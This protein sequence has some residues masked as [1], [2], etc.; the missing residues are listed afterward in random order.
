M[1][2][3]FIESLFC[4]SYIMRSDLPHLL[5][6]S[7]CPLVGNT[8]LQKMKKHF[9]DF[10]AASKAAMTEL[11]KAG[12]NAKQIE[13]L[14]QHKK[15]FDSSAY[16]AETKRKNIRITT[17]WDSDFPKLL[18]E[19]YRPPS[20]LYSKG[21]FS[22]CDSVCVAVVGSRKMTPYGKKVVTKIT[23]KLCE[24]GITVVS[25]LALGIDGEAHSVCLQNGG[26]TIGVLASGIETVYP[27]AHHP[28]ANQISQKGLL[29]SEFPIHA[30][31][32]KEY[33]PIRNR[34]IA[35]LAKATIIVEAKERSGALITAY[36]ALE[37]NR[38]VV[39]VPGNIDQ[40]GSKGTNELISKGAKMYR[41][42]QD[43][44]DILNIDPRPSATPRYI[45]ENEI[46]KYILKRL[47]D[48]MLE[49]NLLLAD[50]AYPKSQMLA[51]IS[52]LEL[53]EV[54]AKN[55]TAVSMKSMT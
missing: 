8:S 14:S 32:A 15:T 17:L 16:F 51:T 48:G 22:L 43:I 49:V 13:N 35:G 33:F 1:R 45:A 28:L 44:L 3:F 36:S 21:N 40:P 34:I 7:Q 39:S 52:L 47:S 6:L 20:I 38:E 18:K 26:N 55:G 5:A 25:G 30:K 29:L 41:S 37:N 53:K 24:H 54:I 2:D 10:D 50:A 46:E 42:F 19:I 27:S 23:E 31:P 4:F 9:G 11:Q 12:L